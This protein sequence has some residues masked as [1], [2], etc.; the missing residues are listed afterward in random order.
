MMHMILQNELYR[1]EETQVTQLRI[2]Q[3]FSA[4]SF[5][6]TSLEQGPTLNSVRQTPQDGLRQD[7]KVVIIR[8]EYR[9]LKL[10]VPHRVH[11]IFEK[12]TI[13]LCD[14]RNGRIKQL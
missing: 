12:N 2:R 13:S 5:T 10:V 3:M 9:L 1:K 6:I 4:T 14:S 8:P 11:V 7:P